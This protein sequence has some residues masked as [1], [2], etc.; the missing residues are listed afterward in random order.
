MS[1]FKKILLYMIIP[2]ILPI[3]IATMVY[4]ILLEPSIKQTIE[5]GINNISITL[6]DEIQQAINESVVNTEILAEN[7]IIKEKNL[8]VYDYEE[9]LRKTR[10]FHN[11]FKDISL[12]DKQG[13]II[14]SVDYSFR[15][16]IKQTK[17]FQ[18]ALD[19][20]IVVSDIHSLLYPFEIVMTVICP[21]LD[22]NNQIQS[23]IVG[24]LDLNRIWSITDRISDRT[25]AE[26]WLLDDKGIVI[27][28]P[29]KELILEKY[30]DEKIYLSARENEQIKT[31]SGRNGKQL[32]IFLNPFT[33]IPGIYKSEWNVLYIEENFKTYATMSSFRKIIL[34]IGLVSLLLIS[35]LSILFSRSLS[36]RIKKLRDATLELGDRNYDIEIHDNGTDEVSDLI[37][38]FN[39]TQ[40][41]LQKSEDR[42]ISANERFELAVKGAND[43]IWDWDLLTNKIYFAPKWIEI[44]GLDKI[45]D[46][47]TPEDW[48]NIIH[49]DDRDRFRK[50]LKDHFKDKSS[51]FKDEY[52]IVRSDN[53]I[54]WIMTRAVVI[55]DDQDREIRMAGSHSDI[56]DRKIMQQKV[57]F[58][59]YYDSLTELPNRTMLLDRLHQALYRA[60]RKKDFSFCVLYLDFDGFKHV[61]DT[62]GH[63]VGDLLLIMIANRLKDCI[64][65]LDL[66]S[67]IGGDEFII[68]LDGIDSNQFIESIVE[69]ILRSSSEEF[70]I[71]DHS[72]YIS[73]SIGIVK[74]SDGTSGADDLIQK[75]DIAMYY[76]KMNGKD[77]FTYFDESLQKNEVK[78]WSLEHELHNALG[79]EALQ[80]YYQPIINSVT[81]KIFSFEA[82]LRWKHPEKGMIPP[83]EF[84]P[85]AEETGFIS[86]IT[87]WLIEEV[88]IQAAFW[89]KNRTDNFIKISF[90]VTAKDFLIPGGLDLLI[91]SK[92]FN[93]KC[94]PQWIALEVTERTMIKDFGP[95]MKQIRKIRSMG[96]SIELDD[97]GTGYS[98]LSY[99]NKFEIDYLKID[100][101]FIRS[102]M[103]DPMS[104]KIVKTIINLA[105]DLELSI[106][107]EGVETPEEADYLLSCGCEFFQGYFYSRPLNRLD[108]EKFISQVV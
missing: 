56:T 67:R 42:Y 37:R 75:S 39:M 33:S 86:K 19:G 94:N 49:L 96:I 14:A 71:N 15:G 21:V 99:L 90:N 89:N 11:I 65:P 41:R 45:D 43:A 7:P 22:G 102:M 81:Q 57:S 6:G 20:E 100:Q 85:S 106:I 34:F 9:E 36:S 66:V 50:K 3:I 107:A 78:R 76:S 69:R 74:E 104:Y 61:N 80:I 58:Y 68:L 17:W 32:N 28:S 98:S 51:Y 47:F 60:A 31:H 25:G 13:K 91:E 18:K 70:Q 82:L 26:I 62:Y 16:N 46:F 59:A 93:S 48:F 4:F 30:P 23:F 2:G 44:I 73:V 103:K 1:F 97:F 29:D 54:K 87:H 53:Q 95:V 64:R 72:I 38:I 52:R 105:H 10:D 5:T 92:L 77:Q 84:I 24:Q 88:C 12:T 63:A 79:T 101:S 27:A 8:S 35:F 40:K 83:D 55:Y 108:A